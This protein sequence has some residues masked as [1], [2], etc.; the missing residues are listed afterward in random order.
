MKDCNFA[1]VS[2]ADFMAKAM[3]MLQ[4]PGKDMFTV[5]HAP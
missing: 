2:N 4:M 1:Y 5:G 3:G